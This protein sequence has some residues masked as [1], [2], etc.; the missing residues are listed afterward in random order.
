[1]MAL[2]L[3]HMFSDAA[4]SVMVDWKMDGWVFKNAPKWLPASISTVSH[5]LF[6]E[7]KWVKKGSS[8]ELKVFKARGNK[9]S[10]QY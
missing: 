1:M 3:I 4:Y 7:I 10:A 2:R 9:S 8:S 6:V 5:Q